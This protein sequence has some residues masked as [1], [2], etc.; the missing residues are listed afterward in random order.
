MVNLK[1]ILK[2]R[3]LTTSFKTDRG[4]VTV[5]TWGVNQDGEEILEF[6]RAVLV[7]KREG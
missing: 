5:K 1:T 7:P 6:E 4:I 2:V 3:H